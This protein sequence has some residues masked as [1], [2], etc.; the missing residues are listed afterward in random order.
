MAVDRQRAALLR[1]YRK[2]RRDLPWRRTS[3][4]YAIWV[5]EIMLQQ[6]QVNTVLP[7]YTAFLDRFPDV[8]SLAVA[9]EDDVLARWSGLGYYRRA[10]SMH[11]AAR[12]IAETHGGAVPSHA[13]T[14]RT[15]PG[16]GRYTAG[17]IASIAFGR[18]E[19]IL[20][21]NVRRVLARWFGVD[22]ATSTRTV[23]EKRL[24]ELARKLADGPSPGDLNQALMELGA[25]V[26]LPR[27]P[28][29]PACP[30]RNVC[31]A[32][33]HDAVDRFPAAT[34]RKTSVSVRVGVAVIRRG[35]TI[36]L[37]RPDDANPLRGRWELP[38]VELEG[39]G[40]AALALERRLKRRHRVTVAI[41]ACVGR[42][43]HGILHRRLKLEAHTGKL[44]RGRVRGS[45][46]LA[47]IPLS[48]LDARPVSGATHKVLRLNRAPQR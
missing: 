33:Q 14:L 45:D 9:S 23:E 12:E 26:C 35:D 40:L 39:A 48:E 17:A 2:H 11:R 6:T 22:G 42:A 3:D 24:W 43:T 18:P 4:P 47:W 13:E 44:Q 5:S 25:R 19:P 37:E 46:E 10:R 8:D 29:C 1:W 21:G 27:E 28:D 31:F 41:G 7:Y 16:I 34:P 32:R 15:L 20:D 38:A 36:L 30:L